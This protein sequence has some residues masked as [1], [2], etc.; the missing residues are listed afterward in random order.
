[1]K[2]YTFLVVGSQI[3]IHNTPLW[4][5]CYKVAVTDDLSEALD[6]STF[7]RFHS[8]VHFYGRAFDLQID[9]NTML[10][11]QQ[12]LLIATAITSVFGHP[13]TERAA[14]EPIPGETSLYNSY[15]G[16]AAPYPG[17]ITGAI[18]PTSNEPAAPDDLLFQNL[19]AAEWV[20]FSLYQQAVEAFNESSFTSLGFPN[21]TYDRISEIRDNEAGHLNIF[22][23]A[24]T[25]SS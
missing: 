6:A 16:I 10:L 8:P 12:H 23:S 21:T 9:S 18:R 14:A 22:Y 3:Q 5:S 20:V 7:S 4:A 15:R 13:T 25:E 2:E 17:N 19:L 24:Y 11:H 1:M